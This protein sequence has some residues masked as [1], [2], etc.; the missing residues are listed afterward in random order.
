MGSVLNMLDATA[1]DWKWV[2][3]ETTDRKDIILV[4]EDSPRI[5][6]ILESENIDFAMLG[7]LD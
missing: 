4:F 5:R 7:E 3:D 6:K 1:E 2:D